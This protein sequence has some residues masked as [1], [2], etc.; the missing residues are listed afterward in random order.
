MDKIIDKNRIDL[1]KSDIMISED[2]ENIINLLSY[3]LTNN[4]GQLAGSSS[5]RSQINYSD[6]DLFDIVKLKDNQTIE[7]NK[8]EIYARFMSK[9]DLIK[10][11]KSI[12]WMTDFKCG[13][14]DNLYINLRTNS[15]QIIINFY[16]KKDLEQDIFKQM[17]DLYQKHINNEKDLIALFN[18]LDYCRK[19]YTLRWSIKDLELGYKTLDGFKK[20]FSDAVDDSTITKLDL[21]TWNKPLFNEFSN[22]YQFRKG[23]KAI[24]FEFDNILKALRK[25]LTLFYTQKKFLKTLK[26]LFVIANLEANQELQL[27]LTGLFNSDIGLCYKLNGHLNN[28]LEIIQLDNKPTFDKIRISI[29]DIKMKLSNVWSFE[30]SDNVFEKLDVISKKT[31]YE[32]I[33][34]EL[35]PIVNIFNLLINMETNRYI[36][37]MKLKPIIEPYLIS[38]EDFKKAF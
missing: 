1:K 16:R 30:F 17:N 12:M 38:I 29:Q 5:L 21:I 23:N 28:I 26:R 3:D 10:K 25:D 19:L 15:P 2:I 37:K 27:I 6:Y 31:N 13:I 35:E 32:E 9:I 18:F 33:F 14:N 4:K 8:K 11:N 34:N 7:Q 20:T 36:I 22:I 24:N